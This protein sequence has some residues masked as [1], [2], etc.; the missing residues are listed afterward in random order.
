[1]KKLITLLLLFLI[2][3]TLLSFNTDAEEN[4]GYENMKNKYS[5]LYAIDNDCKPLVTPNGIAVD[6]DGNI[7]ILNMMFGKVQVYNNNKFLY[8]YS[9]SDRG[10]GGGSMHIKI[11]KDDNMYLSLSR[12]DIGLKFN[13]KQLIEA[14]D[15]YQDYTDYP[16]NDNHTC[17]DIYGNIYK[18]HSILGY[19]FVTK[20]AKNGANII[21]YSIPILHFLF[22]LFAGIIFITLFILITIIVFKIKKM[23]KEANEL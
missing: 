3:I 10:T 20:N 21:V 23:I 12:S 6:S 19:D 5:Y 2:T 1:M 11:D 15:N 4:N 9:I 18:L 14:V 13:D 16:I 8:S 17:S 22:K 7:Y